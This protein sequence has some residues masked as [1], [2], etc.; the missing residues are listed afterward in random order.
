[1]FVTFW[2]SVLLAALETF[3]KHQ[4]VWSIEIHT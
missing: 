3:T 2:S 4:S 1:M